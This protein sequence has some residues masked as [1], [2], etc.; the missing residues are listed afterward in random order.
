MKN[1]ISLKYSVKKFKS[2]SL[3]LKFDLDRIE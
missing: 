2:S 3:L 1:S